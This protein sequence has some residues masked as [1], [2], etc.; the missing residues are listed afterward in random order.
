MLKKR[1]VF[2]PDFLS[3][4]NSNGRLTLILI[5]FKIIKNTKIP[6]NKIP[7]IMTDANWNSYEIGTVN[8]IAFNNKANA[9]R[10]NN[11]PNTRPTIRLITANNV[12]STTCNN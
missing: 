3:L 1:P 11:T 8:R 4:N 9:N 10:L 7:I 5:A 2:S 6:L 12:I